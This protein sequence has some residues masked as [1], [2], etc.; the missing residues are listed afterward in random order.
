MTPIGG[1]FSVEKNTTFELMTF[2]HE[3]NTL[4]KVDIVSCF[5]KAPRSTKKQD[6]GMRKDTV[7]PLPWVL[8]RTNIFT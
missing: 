3:N 2:N 8:S 7:F 1:C 4:S 6:I 5:N